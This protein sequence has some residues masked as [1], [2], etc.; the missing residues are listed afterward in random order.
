VRQKGIAQSGA[1]RGAL[2]E[3]GN[4][5]DFENGRDNGRGFVAFGQVLELLIRDDALET[6]S[7]VIG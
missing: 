3:T 4:V 7:I 1:F 5:R 6:A 2:D